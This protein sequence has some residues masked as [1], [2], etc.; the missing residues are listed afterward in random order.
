MGWVLIYVEFRIHWR[1]LF[2]EFSLGSFF[3]VQN[4]YMGREAHEKGV[5]EPSA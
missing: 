5:S 2:W 3:A 4:I 1:A